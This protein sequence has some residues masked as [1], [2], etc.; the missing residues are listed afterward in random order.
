MKTQTNR[1]NIFYVFLMAL[2]IGN[3][4]YAQ[5]SLKTKKWS[6]V[7]P[8]RFTNL[9]NDNTMLSGIKVGRSI[10]N[11]FNVSVS[12]YHSFYLKSFKSKADII[13]F[14]EQPRL[15][16][17]CMGGEIEYYLL[18]ANRIS[19]GLQLL[20]GWGFMT[21]ELKEYNFVSKPVNYLVAEPALNLEYKANN[22][23][24]VG[25]GIGYR[26]ILS[27]RQIA[28]TSDISNGEVPIQK[29]V[30]NGLNLILTFKGHF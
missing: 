4:V 5:D 19:L 27:D 17:N 2:T 12:I 1:R 8:L 30:P 20:L 28:Y 13:G 15:F 16:I 14:N 11:K 22:T 18:K 24:F 26:P 21:Y 3:S 25:L 6:V 7:L 29:Q 9:Q 10:N 23:C